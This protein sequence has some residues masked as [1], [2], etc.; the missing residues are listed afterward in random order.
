MAI[1]YLVRHGEASAGWSDDPDP[2]LSTLGREQA[3]TAAAEMAALGPLPIIVSPLQ[4]C[5]ETAQP[6]EN[7]WGRIATVDKRVAEIPSPDG[8]TDRGAWLRNIMQG[9]WQQAN[10]FLQPWRQS[11]ID[12]LYGLTEDTV[13]QSHFVALNVAAGVAMGDD[14]VILFQPDNCSIT[15]IE[16]ID[17]KLKV[18]ELGRERTTK[19]N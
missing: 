19:V 11:V 13:V 1:V 17:N 7:L 18:L 6:L 16:V 4:R 5:R 12:C 8:I 10:S 14:R 15:K 3:A 9:S 2:G